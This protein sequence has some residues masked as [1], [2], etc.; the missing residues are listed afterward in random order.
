MKI[1]T[2]KNFL[3]LVL[4]I[5][6]FTSC[7][8]G[9]SLYDPDIEFNPDPVINSI[10]PE[11]GYLAGVD[12]III[13]GE[14]FSTEEDGNL[15]FFDGQAGIVLS[16]TETE[17]GVRP[18]QVIGDNIEVKVSSLGA[19]NFSNTVTY[20]LDKV[21]YPIPGYNQIHHTT[22]LTKNAAGDIIFSLQDDKGVNQGVKVWRT[23]DVV[24]DY[25][26]SKSNWVAMKVGPDGLL[27]AVRNIYAVYRENAGDIDNSPYAIGNTTE[28]YRNLDFGSDNYLWVVGNNKNIIRVDIS[29]ASIERFPFTADLRAV[30]YFDGKLYVGGVVGGN[31]QIW[32]FDVVNNQLQNKTLVVEIDKA[33]NP[34]LLIQEITFSEDGAMYIGANTGSGIY[35][36]TEEDGLKAMYEGLVKPTGFSF[37][38]VESFLVASITAQD[39]TTRHPLKIDTRKEGAPYLG[40]E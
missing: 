10:T 24:E 4:V 1:A 35:T 12:S 34:N 2:I 9:D 30:R 31:E 33:Q 19:L 29:D 27:Y 8:E 15:V 32:S 39:Q 25:L 18:A 40:V 13:H 7:K 17:L 16:A 28:I 6:A 21:I 26:P 3:L 37:T 14:N 20:K 22:G 11:E 38:W 36:W 5:T 23:T